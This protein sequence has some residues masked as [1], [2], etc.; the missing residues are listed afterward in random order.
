M[1]RLTLLL[2][3]LVLVGSSGC[4][5]YFGDD[6]DDDDDCQWGGA[7]EAPGDYAP[8][9]L[10]DPYT[11]LCQDFGGGGGGGCD[12]PCGPC[13]Y[14]EPA[15]GED[16]APLPSWGECNNYCS[17]LDETSC[18]ATAGCRGG[19][20]E[21]CI[22]ETNGLCDYSQTKAFYECWAV[23]QTG[24]VVGGSCEG[25]DAWSCSQHD[26]CVAVHDD[27][28]DYGGGEVPPGGSDPGGSGGAEPDALAC[29][30]GGFIQCAPEGELQF[31]ECDDNLDCAEGSY[32]NN[33][34]LCLPPPPDGGNGDQCES[35][36]VP[37]PCWG[38]CV[39]DQNVGTCY[40]PVY[41]DSLPPTCPEGQT[42]G[43]L[44]GCWS[45][46]CIDQCEEQP[47]CE[48]LDE[49]TCVGR[50]DCQAYYQGIDCTC[51]PDGSCVCNDWIYTSC[52]SNGVEPFDPG[53]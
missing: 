29:G 33:F 7:E 11:G 12:D 23:D 43:V 2:G 1:R 9:F 44:N 15:P 13:D 35:C 6:D 4:H 20:I 21:T 46:F 17:G 22:D 51:G 32:C 47:P 52:M 53:V 38:Y 37:Q 8:Y 16:R 31:P 41:C 36:G 28:C 26:D 30:I 39:P 34:E 27:G 14:D 5:I 18:L 50:E 10:R 19:Y 42:P 3:L 25:L 24:P 49:D 45:G 48:W 40:E